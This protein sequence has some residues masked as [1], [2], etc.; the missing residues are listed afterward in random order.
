VYIYHLNTPNRSRQ[1]WA[2]LFGNGLIGSAIMRSLSRQGQEY[3][4]ALPSF[5]SQR[6]A[7]RAQYRKVAEQMA[8]RAKTAELDIEMIWSA[9]SGSFAS[10]CEALLDEQ[11]AF[12]DTLHLF[13]SVAGLGR[14]RYHYFSSAGGLYEGQVQVHPDAKPLP[15]RPYGEM[16]LEQEKQL[17]E[18]A[19]RYGGIS[20]IYRPSTVYGAREFGRRAGLVSHL[21]WN[22]LRNQ[23]TTLESHVDALRVY[24]WVDDVGAYIARQVLDRQDRTLHTD[25]LVTAKPTSIHEIANRIRRMLGKTLLLQYSNRSRNDAHI[26]FRPDLMPKGWHPTG[27]EQGLRAVRRE[28]ANIYLQDP[29]EKVDVT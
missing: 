27:L 24:V 29:A 20:R 1:A 10:T 8:A 6:D 9:G 14:A 22:A 25:F 17:N 11:A 19:A 5:W 3:S 21:F 2:L 13:V 28:T 12:E 18:C 23:A 26:T 15:L 16:K 7:R 4:I